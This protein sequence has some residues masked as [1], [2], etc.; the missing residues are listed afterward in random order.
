MKKILFLFFLCPLMATAEG[1]QVLCEKLF[2]P[3]VKTLQHSDAESFST[4]FP[5]VIS[6]NIF[7]EQQMYGKVQ[8]TQIMKDL[9]DRITVK[10]I[11]LKHCSGKELLKYAVGELTDAAGLH[12]RITIFIHIGAK[13]EITVQ[14]F[15]IKKQE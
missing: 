3:I 15:K 12:Y 5:D 8:A 2:D 6:F 7:G 10:R 9:F 11:V 4:Y 14:Q 13:D 1:S